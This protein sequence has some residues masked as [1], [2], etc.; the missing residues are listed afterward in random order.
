[1]S[2]IRPTAHDNQILQGQGLQGYQKKLEQMEKDNQSRMDLLLN[3]TKKSRRDASVPSVFAESLQ[4][5]PISNLPTANTNHQ[6]LPA[7]RPA[8]CG[9]SWFPPYPYSDW[10]HDSNPEQARL[11]PTGCTPSGPN[12]IPPNETRPSNF[13]GHDLEHM[14]G[15]FMTEQLR[16]HPT[17]PRVRF[18][19][20]Q[21][22]GLSSMYTQMTEFVSHYLVRT[23]RLI[24]EDASIMLS[25]S[26]SHVVSV[27]PM[28]FKSPVPMGLAKMARV[29]SFFTNPE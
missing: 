20:I 1:M 16:Y 4:L 18:L 21:P 27:V 7:L 10:G 8:L 29:E 14:A 11:E 23:V 28:Y 5:T 25:L 19:L 9:N 12:L 3:S 15:P 2:E 22:S 17:C 6:V 24:S 13:E 26:R